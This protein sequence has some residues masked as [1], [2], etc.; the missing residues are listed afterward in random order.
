MVSGSVDSA[1]SH[2]SIC[3][4]TTEGGQESSSKSKLS[5][6]EE[7]APHGDENTEADKGEA[8]T[9]SNGQ[10]A[11]DGKEGQECPQTRDTLTGISYV[12][13]THEDTNPESDSKEKTQSIQQKW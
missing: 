13:G 1:A 9:S 4:H 6:D 5:H 3:S 10:V 12:S 2:H 11:S 8:E 7:D